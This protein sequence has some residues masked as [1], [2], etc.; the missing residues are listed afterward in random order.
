[1][2]SKKRPLPQAGPGKT[3]LG[4]AT[5][6]DRDLAAQHGV[7]YVH[8]SVFAIDVDRVFMV[9]HED[10]PQPMGWEVCLCLAYLLGRIN[11][12]DEPQTGMLEDTC[13]H[14]LA[15]PP[16]E[17]PLGSELTF[18]VYCGLQAGVL[19]PELRS[20]FR[21][22]K[23]KP[24][25]LQKVVDSFLAEPQGPLKSMAEH[26]LNAPLDPPLAPP[27]VSVLKEMAAGA[28]NMDY[29]AGPNA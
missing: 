22:W 2:S 5:I 16:G 17:A 24:K 6:M 13:L 18:A 27:T 10:S 25:Q 26:C 19:S 8:L 21:T 11:T 23:A 7:P 14:I 29:F 9:T 20:A 15:S 1:M 28:F 12:N 3:G 4:E